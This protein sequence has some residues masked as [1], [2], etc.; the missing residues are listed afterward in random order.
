MINSFRP[1]IRS[2]TLSVIFLFVGLIA[3]PP[4]ALG[5]RRPLGPEWREEVAK[6]DAKIRDG[7][8]KA[9]GRKAHKLAEEVITEAWFG[10]GLRE[11]LAELAFLQAVAAANLG[12][13]DKAIWYWHIAWNV[14]PKIRDHD[15]APYGAAGKLLREF[16]L[17]RRGEAPPAYRVVD[18]GICPTCNFPR[19][20]EKWDPAIPP[21]AAK[22][23]R[24]VE[25]QSMMRVEII[26]DRE[27]KPLH[28]VVLSRHMHPVAIYGALESL[29]TLPNFTPA[30]NYGEAVDT[31]WKFRM[32]LEHS[33]WEQGGAK[34]R[35]RIE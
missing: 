23:A 24:A 34:L 33:R 35:G 25:A 9:G 12:E 5:E 14:D 2:I 1:P 16:P 4:G 31:L 32:N 21:N 19:L 22:V 6:V 10:Q 28:P 15:L 27:G 18:P 3:T 11:I 20:A 7:N 8:W 26:I 30:H 29:R 17:R 13:R